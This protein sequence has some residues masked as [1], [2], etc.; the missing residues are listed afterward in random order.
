M[1]PS[2]ATIDTALA[3]PIDLVTRFVARHDW[4]V[5]QQER[6]AIIA[7]IPG[8]WSD[9]QLAVSWQDGEETMQVVCRIDVRAEQAQVG[10]VA[11]LA[12]LLNQQLYI[13]HLAL[14]MSTCELE[15]R[16]TLALRGAGGATPEQVEDV[17]DIMLGECEQVYPAIYQVVT[18]TLN[19][20]DAATAVMMVTCF[21]AGL[22]TAVSMPNSLLSNRRR[23]ILRGR[24][25]TTMSGSMPQSPTPLPA[26][27][28]PP[29]WC[30]RSSRR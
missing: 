7:E 30:L 10:E 9:Y 1:A 25:R 22:P 29:W 4:L 5:R 24:R 8:R 26:G 11:L 27:V 21:M 6:D 20:G 16:H 3:H 19:A 17:V 15:L 2:Q 28:P 23:T 18:G 12:A 14:D 13:G